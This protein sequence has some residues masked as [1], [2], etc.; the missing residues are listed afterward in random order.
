MNN[1][2]DCLNLKDLSK[3]LKNAI[4][5]IDSFE[6]AIET[7]SAQDCAEIYIKENNLEVLYD[8]IMAAVHFGFITCYRKFKNGEFDE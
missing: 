4:Q 8:E 6:N 2:T 5:K 1:N 3:S 7:K